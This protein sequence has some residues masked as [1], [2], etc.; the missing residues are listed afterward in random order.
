[1]K[2]FQQVVKINSNGYVI[3]LDK[4]TFNSF[5]PLPTDSSKTSIDTIDLNPYYNI[6]INKGA[7]ELAIYK[8]VEAGNMSVKYTNGSTLSEKIYICRFSEKVAIG[9]LRSGECIYIK[10]KDNFISSNNINNEC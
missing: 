9:C 2:P 5:L 1:M 3:Y 6:P 8:T 4:K 10:K 7:I